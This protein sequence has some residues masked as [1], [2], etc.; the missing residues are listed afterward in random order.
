M[1]KRTFKLDLS[2]VEDFVR[3][4]EDDQISEW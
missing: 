4:L 3:K 2:P 1:K